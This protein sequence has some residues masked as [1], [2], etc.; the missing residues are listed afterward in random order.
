MRS[1]AGLRARPKRII[2]CAAFKCSSHSA[3]YRQHATVTA[4]AAS[5][6]AFSDRAATSYGS[7]GSGFES[8]GTCQLGGPA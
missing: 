8:I 2:E 4:L 1:R 6:E 5:P 3:L 7:E